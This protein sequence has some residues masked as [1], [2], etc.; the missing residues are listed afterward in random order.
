MTAPETAAVHLER[1]IAAITEALAIADDGNQPVIGAQL[2]SLLRNAT[3]YRIA[4]GMI[5]QC[6]VRQPESHHV[7]AR[8]TVS[9]EASWGYIVP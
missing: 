6:S 2:D 4:A 8:C 9:D 5:E 3:G 7:A 1:L